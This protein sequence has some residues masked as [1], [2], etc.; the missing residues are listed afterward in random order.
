[1]RLTV[2]LH[3]GLLPSPLP[4]PFT[5]HTRVHSRTTAGT[6]PRLALQLAFPP[7]PSAF[8]D[9]WTCFLSN[10]RQTYCP[11]MEV[12]TQSDHPNDD[13]VRWG[14]DPSQALTD[15]CLDVLL[16]VQPLRVDAGPAV[17]VL[18]AERG[19]GVPH[20]LQSTANGTAQA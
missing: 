18:H 14:S 15:G 2:F 16:I 11:S 17:L 3:A 19:A 5:L 20:A 7:S 12:S 6:R 8:T 1:M 9:A 4:S 13:A 10:V